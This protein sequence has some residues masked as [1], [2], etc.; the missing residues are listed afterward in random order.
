MHLLAYLKP[1]KKNLILVLVLATINQVFSML[2]P[3]VFRRL[4]DNYITKID[5]L[6]SQ[7][8]V[9]FKGIGMGLWGMVVVAMVSRVA[10]NFQD[11]F[12]NVMSQN[13]GLK[14]FADTISHAFHLPYMYLEDQS[15]GQLLQNIQKAKTDIQQ[16]FLNLINIVFT[17]LVTII[18]VLFMA[19]RTHWIIG[20]VILMLFPIMGITSYA[21]SRQIKKAQDSIVKESAS[22]A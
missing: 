17:S 9:L 12:A 1:Y 8:D 10:K 11:Y 16:F 19:F 21:L 20:T 3:W 22:L 4:T 2:D 6:K 5:S 15:S 7:P 14:I 18:F 13:I